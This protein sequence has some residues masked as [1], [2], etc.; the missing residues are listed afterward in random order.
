MGGVVEGLLTWIDYFL[1][2][3]VRSVGIW[4]RAGW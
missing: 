4:S 1:V 2:T 3:C